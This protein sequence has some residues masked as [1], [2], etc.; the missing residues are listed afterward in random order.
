MNILYAVW[1]VRYIF[2]GA[3]LLCSLNILG[4]QA[5]QQEF[6]TIAI[7]AKDKAHTLPFYLQCIENQTWP[8]KKTY[9]YI[10]TNNNNDDTVR[11]LR[12]WMDRVYNQYA[13]IYFDDSNVAQPVEQYKQHEWNG[14][15]FKVLG[16]IRQDSVDWAHAHNSHYFVADC[17]NFIVP[18][19]IETL[20][21]SHAPIV[22][23][24]LRCRTQS[25]YSNYHMAIDPNGY[26]ENSPHYFT[27]FDCAI[28]G[29]IEVPVVH[30]TYLVRREFLHE[31]SYDDES[32]RYEY[33]IFSDCARKKN[34][35]QY[36]DNRAIYGYVSFAETEEEFNEERPFLDEFF[37]AY[38]T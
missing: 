13:Y 5:Q 22:G 2:L 33:V 27:V 12:E 20:V 1:P 29:L 10:R 28:K 31:V 36:L 19:T 3:F 30:C 21:N 23:P 4:G 32:W 35:A 16:K 9:I 26:Y 37:A 17:D 38:R 7:L 8:K 15:R 24:L 14:T 25:C 34:I 18:K 11:V 6:V